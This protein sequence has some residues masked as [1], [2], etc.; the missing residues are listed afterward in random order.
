MAVMRIFEEE[1][2]LVEDNG[3]PDISAVLEH[4]VP[5]SPRSATNA[6]N[7]YSLNRN[8]SPKSNQQK[9]RRRPRVK[10]DDAQLKHELEA[11]QNTETVNDLHSSI[12][13]I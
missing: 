11:I 9:N 12:S 13:L 7:F 1:W 10:Q 3:P 2:A 6:S 5:R 4:L 8:N